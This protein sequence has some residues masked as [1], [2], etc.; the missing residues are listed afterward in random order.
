MTAGMSAGNLALICDCDGVLIDSEAVAARMLVQ[1]LQA[2]WPGA[3]VEPVVLPLL[4]LRIESVL[5]GTAMQLGK[6]LGLDDIRAIRRSVE[7][8]AVQASAVQG[9]EHALAQVPLLKGCASNSFRPY[10]ETVLARTGLV[11]FFGDRL[12]CADSVANPKPAPD[13][14]LA[15]ARGLR[16]APSACLVVEDSVT[17]VTAASAAGMTVLGFIGG[18]HASDAQID[19]LHAAGA[20]HVFDDMLQLPELVAQWTLSATAAAP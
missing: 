16:L 12:F 15:A 6:S 20:R 10:V 8:A 4:G 2:R 13:V 7:A 1:E 9:I 18:G 5:E 11:R 17:G 19:K 3:D 14:Y